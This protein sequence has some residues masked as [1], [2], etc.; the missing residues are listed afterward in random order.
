MNA[1]PGSAPPCRGTH[2]I[3]NLPARNTT[4]RVVEHARQFAAFI[5]LVLFLVISGFA[6]GLAA[7]DSRI[8]EAR[9]RISAENSARADVSSKTT[10]RVEQARRSAW[11][12]ER[13]VEISER[14]R[15]AQIRNATV[16]N[17]VKSIESATE[18]IKRRGLDDV[19]QLNDLYG[20][21]IVVQ[22]ELD[23]YRCLN[24]LCNEFEVVPGTLKNY[25]QAPK[26]SGYQSVH[27]VNNIDGRRV[28]FQLRTTAMHEQAEA[29]HEAYK[30]R[31][32]VA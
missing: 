2:A 4:T 20:M 13:A 3:M 5:G 22:N 15:R 9:S 16:Y 25:I 19:E 26:A 6:N 11:L 18:K 12:G 1:V 31:V 30:K 24:V 29:E 32:R 23:V 17:R 8:S 10:L 14:L 7:L 27:V 28:E 21:R